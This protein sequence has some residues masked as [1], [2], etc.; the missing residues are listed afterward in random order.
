MYRGHSHVHMLAPEGCPLLLD[1][2]ELDV[3]Q[4]ALVRRVVCVGPVRPVRATPEGCA[5]SPGFK[6]GSVL[7]DRV[8]V[9]AD[10]A[11]RLPGARRAQ[12]VVPAEQPDHPSGGRVWL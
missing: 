5:P 6:H 2:T 8:L 4:S 1:P 7:A 12:P 10:G 11:R 3:E 9:E